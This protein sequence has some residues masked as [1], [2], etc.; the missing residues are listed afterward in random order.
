MKAI[1]NKRALIINHEATIAWAAENRKRIDNEKK[2]TTENKETKA[3]QVLQKQNNSAL[4]KSITL[5]K[6][7]DKAL[8][9]KFRGDQAKL[10]SDLSVE[11]NDYE[12]KKRGRELAFDEK[13]KAEPN[14]ARKI[15]LESRF[16]I[17]MLQ[18]AHD[19]YEKTSTLKGDIP[20]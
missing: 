7:A 14:K 1:H 4:S 20:Q 19:Y 11:A 18:Y 3:H 12:Q 10:D 17:D 9:V 16:N 2:K 15:L 6:K 8:K 13:K 5:A